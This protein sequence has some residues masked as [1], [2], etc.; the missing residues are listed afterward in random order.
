ME[1]IDAPGNGIKE[2][3]GA[4]ANR[5]GEFMVIWVI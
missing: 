5:A 2:K 4:A 1:E 3:E